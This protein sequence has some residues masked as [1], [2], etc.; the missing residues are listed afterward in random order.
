MSPFVREGQR[1]AVESASPM[2]GLGKAELLLQKA[3][4]S[5]P[6]YDEAQQKAVNSTAL[7]PLPRGA[8]RE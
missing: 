5:V 8:I 1:S 4:C 2:A 7:C 3:N 6:L